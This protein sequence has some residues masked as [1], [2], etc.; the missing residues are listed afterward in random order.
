MPQPP[1]LK[2]KYKQSTGKYQYRKH[3]D[4]CYKL[5]NNVN[6][7]HEMN[8]ASNLKYTNKMKT[9]YQDRFTH[10]IEMRNSF[11]SSV[12]SGDVMQ[13][14]S[15]Q[16]LEQHNSLGKRSSQNNNQPRFLLANSKDYHISTS[17]VFTKTKTPL[18][19]YNGKD[20]QIIQIPMV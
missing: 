13:Y 18:F 12:K 17:G 5:L 2:V 7:F 14:L 10:D 16:N 6:L 1:Y 11:A 20:N 15:K 19:R 8:P 4:N 3:S 9:F